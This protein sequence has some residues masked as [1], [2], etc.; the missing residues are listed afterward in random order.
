MP[1]TLPVR[2]VGDALARLQ[3]QGLEA[4]PALASL[5]WDWEGPLRIRRYDVLVY[6]W[7][8]WP[9]KYLASLETKR[10]VAAA[11]AALL[12][13][14]GAAEYATICRTPEVEEMLALW[15]D[16]DTRAR[17]RLRELLDASGLEPPDTELLAC[18]QVMGLVEADAR[19]RATEAL[20]LAREAGD[21][22]PARAI[23]ADVLAEPTDAG[24]RLD[25]IH[26]ERLE[27]WRGRGEP[28]RAIVDRVVEELRTP[29]V[30]EA[31]DAVEPAL[32]LLEHA[33]EGIAPDRRDISW[34][35][36]AFLLRA[37]PAG[38]VVWH[39]R[40]LTAA[41]RAALHHGLRAR[42]LGPAQRIL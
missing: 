22:V 14:L 2:A 9:T 8:Q 18:G 15:E 25:C 36:S 4:E 23:V 12:E 13:Q 10:D 19:D 34:A 16:D 5:G 37:E 11:L 7:Y 20:E 31:G 41:G 42:A 27:R 26:A 32:W 24:T 17:R 21:G 3:E 29:A 38:I 39:E 30:V 1:V 35:V 33:E 6:L 40:R 28:R